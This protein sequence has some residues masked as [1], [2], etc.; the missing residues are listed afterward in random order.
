MLVRVD[1]KLLKI[2]HTGVELAYHH[3]VTLLITAFSYS[4]GALRIGI[5]IFALHNVS[6]AFACLGKAV[7]ALH[8]FALAVT[9]FV[10]LLLTWFICRIILFPFLVIRSTLFDS[11][12]MVIAIGDQTISA[13]LSS[14]LMLF[15][16]FIVN[17]Y[18][19]NSFIRLFLRLLKKGIIT[20][21]NQSMNPLAQT[22]ELAEISAQRDREQIL[23]FEKCKIKDK[24]R[25][26]SRK[27]WKSSYDNKQQSTRTV[28]SL[29]PSLS[30]AQH[31]SP[32]LTQQ[33]IDELKNKRLEESN[34]HSRSYS[35]SS[36][37]FPYPIIMPPTLM[38]SP[39][40]KSN[41]PQTTDQSSE[42]PHTQFAFQ[43]PVFMRQPLLFQSSNA[44]K[45]T[46][47][48]VIESQRK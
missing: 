40:Q 6:E 24:Q 3:V 20:N 36:F 37:A 30:T 35:Y 33:Q 10:M 26:Q 12:R 13:W 47:P 19:F 28:I 8:H 41:S 1:G 45:P 27:Q 16:L 48:S 43:T 7:L 23:E 25:N 4:V 14:N 17:V 34:M 22:A 44:F 11:Y 46:A 38:S 21:P 29:L 15:A 42:S 32:K 2:D 39:K 18:W 9:A 31:D 5:I